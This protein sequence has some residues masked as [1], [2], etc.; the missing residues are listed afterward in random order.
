MKIK[1]VIMSIAVVSIIATA[2]ACNE[3]KK[4]N[5]NF[6]TDKITITYNTQGD[7]F[8]ITD[9][10]VIKTIVDT[11]NNAS[12][13][14]VSNE[15]N[16][17]CTMWIDFHNGLIMGLYKDLNYGYVGHTIMD[18]PNDTYD[19][20]LPSKINELVSTLVSEHIENNN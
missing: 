13:S 14:P 10:D 12:Y 9:G 20:Y 7:H 19:T 11:C 18:V 5:Y 4:D 17:I 8:D 1:R 2:F 3:S 16:G 6:T 15:S